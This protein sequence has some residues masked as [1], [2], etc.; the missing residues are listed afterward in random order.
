MLTEVRS[1]IYRIGESFFMNAHKDQ[2]RHKGAVEPEDRKDEG[3]TSLNGQLGHR[4]QDSR[5][6]N[7]DTDFPEPG[8]NPEHSGEPQGPNQH[9]EE[10]VA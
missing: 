1:A 10:E 8:E 4:D 6:K 5:I 9:L 2:D 7:A 3:N